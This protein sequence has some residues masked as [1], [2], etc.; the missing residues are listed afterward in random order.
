MRKGVG[1]DRIALG[2]AML[3]AGALAFLLATSL[4]G[5]APRRSAELTAQGQAAGQVWG[6]TVLLCQ[7]VFDE[8][9]GSAGAG[10]NREQTLTKRATI[11]D[12]AMRALK[13]R[14]DLRLVESGALLKRLPAGA[15]Q[16]LSDA[17][18]AKAGA[19]AGADT[20]VLVQVLEYGGDLTL[21]LLPPYWQVSIRY[22]YH[23]RVIDARSGAL[24]LDAQRG[25]TGGRLFGLAGRSALDA[26]FL[27]DLREVLALKPANQG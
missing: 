25:R 24:R 17:A 6:E 7:T 21:S 11:M 26:A 2:L 9:A 23:A 12:Q 16:G 15:V 5:C 18:L 13:E 3:V 10:E 22:A 4:G 27:E 20:V 8:G 19:A 1:I 14:P